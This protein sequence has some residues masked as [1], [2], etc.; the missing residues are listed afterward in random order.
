MALPRGV[1]L[2]DA[3]YKD[4]FIRDIN[5]NTGNFAYK[6]KDNAAEY[7]TV[8]VGEILPRPCGTKFNAVGNHYLGV[9]NW[10]GVTSDKEDKVKVQGTRSE[11]DQGFGLKDKSKRFC[12]NRD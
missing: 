7:E 10:G 3:T 2:A 12:E 9:T 6:C 5:A 4:D 1:S 8:L 11:Y